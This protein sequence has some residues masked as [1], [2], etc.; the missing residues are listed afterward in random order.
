V[1]LDDNDLAYLRSWVGTAAP[2]DVELEAAHERLGDLHAVALEVLRQ[3][4]ADLLADPAS[5]GVGSDYRE[6]R[7]SNIRSLEAQVRKL[8]AIVGEGPGA[9]TTG[10]LVRSGRTR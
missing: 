2:T 7:S 6:D 9:L 8:E 10:R 5:F 3:R 1:A 4:L